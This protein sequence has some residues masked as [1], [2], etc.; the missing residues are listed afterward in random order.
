[1]K[2]AIINCIS[3]INIPFTD[4]RVI[5]QGGNPTTALLRSLPTMILYDDKGL[6][7]FDKITYDRDYYLTNAEIEVLQNNSDELVEK[8]VKDGDVLIELGAGA[9]RKTKYILD[10]ITKANRKITYFAVDLAEA[11]LRQ[12]LEPLATTYP[13][14]KFVGLWGTYHDSLSWIQ[15]NHSSSRKLFL[16]LGSSIGNLTRKEGADFLLNVRN[17]AMKDG[18]LFLCG[19]DKRNSFETVS[20][21]YNDRNGLTRDFAMNGLVNINNIFKYTVFD[22]SNFAYVSIYNEKDGRH[23]AYYESARD[24]TIAFR[25]EKVSVQ[26]KKGELINFEY[27]YKYSASEVDDLVKA[28][29]LSVIGKWSSNKDLYDCHL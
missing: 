11:S 29:Q 6:E 28:S 25:D 8:Y 13:S 18:D 24:Q 23:E 20:L 17:T 2:N 16:W 14:I 10:A 12:S 4:S 22:P 21:A 5:R 19:I 9:M 27:S 3:K 26:L 1:M 15:K 7:I